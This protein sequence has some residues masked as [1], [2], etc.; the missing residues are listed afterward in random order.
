MRNTTLLEPLIQTQPNVHNEGSV[1]EHVMKKADINLNRI[2]KYMLR[3][4]FLENR[5]DRR[6]AREAF[7]APPIFA[8]Y[9]QY[10]PGNGQKK[11]FLPLTVSAYLIFVTDPKDISV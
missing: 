5:E 3:N 10:K 4:L 2:R 9:G 1:S 6:K 8:V 11:A 7:F